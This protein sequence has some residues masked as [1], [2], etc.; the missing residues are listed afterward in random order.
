M[1][2]VRKVRMEYAL[3]MITGN[4]PKLVDRMPCSVGQ[5]ASMYSVLHISTR[6]S[7]VSNVPD[8]LNAVLLS[9][10]GWLLRDEIV[11]GHM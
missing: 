4:R 2:I 6:A 5:H 3:T 8:V 11:I 7:S 1:T 9:S 10:V